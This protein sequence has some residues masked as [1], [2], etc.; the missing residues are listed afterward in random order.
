MNFKVPGDVLL[1]KTS[2]NE[3]L[4]AA[5]WLDLCWCWAAEMRNCKPIGDRVCNLSRSSHLM[6]LSYILEVQKA[7][8]H[9]SGQY[10]YW[11]EQTIHPPLTSRTKHR[12]GLECF[13]NSPEIVLSSLI[14]GSIGGFAGSIRMAVHST[15][16][17][18]EAIDLDNRALQSAS[19]IYNREW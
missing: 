13:Q 6:Y 3:N 16:G 7:Q 18:S 15:M 1:R 8:E 10:V 14:M 4:L 17:A 12:H 9:W 5:F 19:L 2:Q 11:K